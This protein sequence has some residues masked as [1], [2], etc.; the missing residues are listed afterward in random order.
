MKLE[1]KRRIRRFSNL[2]NGDWKIYAVVILALIG[3]ISLPDPS[4]M[5]CIGLGLVISVGMF[6]LSAISASFGYIPQEGW[7][8]W[9]E[10]DAD[11]EKQLR[12]LPEEDRGCGPARLRI[13]RERELA[14]LFYCEPVPDGWRLWK[15]NE[16][17]LAPSVYKLRR[18]GPYWMDVTDPPFAGKPITGCDYIQWTMYEICIPVD[19]V[20]QRAPS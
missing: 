19:Y 14:R 15:P 7:R 13:E 16:G 9:D 5:Q 17:D 10:V 3:G 8:T 11:F 1:T 18:A 20:V 4:G 6:I 2:L 12:D